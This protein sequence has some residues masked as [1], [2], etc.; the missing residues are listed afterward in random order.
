MTAPSGNILFRFPSYCIS[1]FSTSFQETLRLLQKQK[2]LFLFGGSSSNSTL[3]AH[4][5][6]ANATCENK[7]V[8][9][10]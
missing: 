9:I 1:M 3:F 2:L 8:N 5:I 4:Y 7:C 6:I 10:R